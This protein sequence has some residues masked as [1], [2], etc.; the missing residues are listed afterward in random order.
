MPRTKLDR[1]K[2]PP[3]DWM[4]AAM[5][6]R[7]QTLSIT[8]DELAA[9]ANVSPAYLRKLMTKKHTDDWKPDIR[10]AVCRELGIG[11][12]TTLSVMEGNDEFRI[13]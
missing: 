1:A 11:V 13:N 12:K 5:L 6:E 9:A 7:K 3:I 8:S 10:R 2:Y 4:K